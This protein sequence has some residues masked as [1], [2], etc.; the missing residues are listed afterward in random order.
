MTLEA[1]FSTLTA[2][3]TWVTVDVISDL[4]LNPSEPATVACWEHYLRHCSSDALVILGD[5]FDAWVGDDAMLEAC[6]FE[7]TC[8]TTLRACTQSRPVF[9]M[10][11]NRDFLTGSFFPQH[12]GVQILDDPTVWVMGSHR[13][14]LTHGDALC[15]DDTP[16]QNFRSLVRTPEWRTSF[17]SQPLAVRR[18]QV[19]A[20]RSASQEHQQNHA[21]YTDIHQGMAQEWMMAA[22]ATALVHGH[23]HHPA[24]HVLPNGCSRHVLSDWD[25]AA[26]PPRAEI[27]R[28]SLAGGVQRI[29]LANYPPSSATQQTYSLLAATVKAG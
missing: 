7:S 21:S 4:H 2:P 5:L 17:L 8:A 22:G 14:L 16:Y 3:P 24:D 27:M 9:F 23:T 26:Q 15:L 11:G 25:G 19:R 1:P 18:E 28:L 6:S 29:P 20:M 12:C 10:Q 13:W